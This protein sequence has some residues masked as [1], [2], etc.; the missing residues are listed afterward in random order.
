MYHLA[1]HCRDVHSGILHGRDFS[2]FFYKNIILIA[3]QKSTEYLF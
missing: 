3:Q 2:A 1:I